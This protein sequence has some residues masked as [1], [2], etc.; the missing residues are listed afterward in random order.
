MSEIM[1]HCSAMWSNV[2]KHSTSLSNVEICEILIPTLLST[3]RINQQPFINK[4]SFQFLRNKKISYL[5]GVSVETDSARGNFYNKL[6]QNTSLSTNYNFTA[7]LTEINKEI[8][9]HTQ[10]KYPITYANKGKEKLN[11]SSNTSKDTTTYLKKTRVESPTKPS[12]HYTPRSAINITSTDASTLHVTSTF[13]RFPFQNF[14]T[15]SLWEVT[16]LEE[17]QEEEEKE[18]SED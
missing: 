15:A 16:D 14:G 10:Q 2:K 18:E 8:E 4:I 6:I 7:I 9:I 3:F 1:A 5:L 11:T 12:Y 17:E 13:R